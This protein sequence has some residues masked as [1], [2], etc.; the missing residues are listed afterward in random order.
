MSRA[1]EGLAPRKLPEIPVACRLSGLEP[2]NIGEDSLFVNVG[3]RTNVTGSAKFK[4]LIKEEKYSEALDVAA[5][6]WKTLRRLS[7]STWMKDA[8]RRSGDGAFSQ[9]DCR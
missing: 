8:R 3:E 5:S 2:L 6:R 9:S 1:V 4:R 7:I